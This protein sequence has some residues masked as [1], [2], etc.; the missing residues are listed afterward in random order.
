MTAIPNTSV[1]SLVAVPTSSVKTDQPL[2]N[3]GLFRQF[4]P[5]DFFK[6][7]ALS[8]KKH[9][10]APPAHSKVSL[11][12]LPPSASIQSFCPPPYDQG[13]LGSCTANAFCGAHKILQNI[14]GVK[15]LFEP[16]R[17]Y[18]YYRERLV[19]GTLSYDAGADVV[20]GEQIAQST[21]VC[22]ESLWPYLIDQYRSV[23]PAACDADALHHKISGFAD[24]AL[25]GNQV[26]NIKAAIA[27]QSPVLLA[28]AVY[29]SFESDTVASTG[30]VPLPNVA[31]EQLLG[32]HEVVAVAYDDASQTFTF[33]NSWGNWGLA[34][35]GT[36]PYG[37]LSNSNLGQEFTCIQL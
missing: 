35:F 6:R 27:A 13:A 11:A 4:V 12:S 30:V 36:L 21:G 29:Q 25:D 20:S 26:Q 7:R 8:R 5:L 14:H 32:G 24:I 9:G 2:V 34:G 3:S 28:I 16:S 17:L 19:E 31:V 22:S 33:L 10:H 37:Y 15:P 1:D 23:P 18:F